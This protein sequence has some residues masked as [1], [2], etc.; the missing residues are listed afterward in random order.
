ML[1]RIVMLSEESYS[2]GVFST[3]ALNAVSQALGFAG[4]LALACWFGTRSDVDIYYYCVGMAFL[5]STFFGNLN[6]SVLV[7]EAMR[8]ERQCSRDDAQAF[9][10]VFLFGYLAVGIVAMV[11]GM[12][13][14][15]SVG[16]LLSRF[17]AS[18]IERH[19]D[20]FSWACVFFGLSNV[21][22]YL[23]DILASRRYF[24]LSV[25]LG[26]A[27]KLG[28]LA[29][30]YGYRGSWG[31]R[32]AF[33]GTCV[34]L[35]V[36]ICCAVFFLKARLGWR[37]QWNL[38][39][40]GA[41]VWK[42]IIFSQTG[43]LVGAAAGAVPLFL[44]SSFSEG[45]LSALGYGQRLAVLPAL[46]VVQPVAGVL[47]IKLNEL[48]PKEAWP[49]IDRIFRGVWHGLM[50]MLV[51]ISVFLVV[52]APEVV[53]LLYMRGN[54]DAASARLTARFFRIFAATIPFLA[55]TALTTRLFIAWQ[56]V[57]LSMMY[58]IANRTVF[59]LF[60]L[61]GIRWFGALGYPLSDLLTW[62]VYQFALLPAIW[63]HF[64][65]VNYQ[66]AVARAGRIAAFS[67]AG[68][69]AALA[70]SRF[71]GN[72]NAWADLFTGSS[73]CL[74][75]WLA[76]MAL[77]EDDRRLVAGWLRSMVRNSAPGAGG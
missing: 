22:Q 76:Q 62:A 34:G 68:G 10:N 14:P 73:I 59:V 18:L 45:T 24:A 17:Q 25:L 54:F 37:F 71:C 56:K 38:S 31:I 23:S 60:L 3:T 74:L 7:P 32:A 42:N 64:S 63:R 53:G 58:Q 44:L 13:A 66:A 33:L 61:L 72:G 77:F 41:R 28:L 26:I 16:R 48:R 9:L 4:N 67:V 50:M 5:A 19:A 57:R 8:L 15:V 75:V 43:H 29:F 52:Y 49:E 69:T 40:V 39:S 70:C 35:L 36:Q 1:V 6:T 30:L 46:F 11:P 20:I 12:A 21:A 2:R 55:S 27:P 51:P 47:G 65:C